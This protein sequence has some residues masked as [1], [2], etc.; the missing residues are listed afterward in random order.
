MRKSANLYC[1]TKST[2]PMLTLLELTACL[3]SLY[4]I[5]KLAQFLDVFNSF[6]ES[7]ITTTTERLSRYSN[8]I[9]RTWFRFLSDSYDWIPI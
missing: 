8:Q 6:F 2:L 5:S 1:N 4:P 7:T 3:G 9:L